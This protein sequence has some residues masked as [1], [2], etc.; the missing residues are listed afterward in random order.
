MTISSTTNTVSYTGNGSTT[1]FAVNYVFFGT[2]TSAE[3]QVVEVVIATG[4]ETVKSNGSD[5]TVSGGNGA[6]GTVTAAV[7]PANTVKWVINRTTTQTQETDY[8]E[9]DP[10]PAESHEEALDRLTAVDQEQ[11]RA[12]DRTAQLPDGYTGSFDPTLPTAI[13][14]STVLAFNAGATA[15]EIGPTTA[16]ISGAAAEAAAAAVS[17]DAS[18]S[19]AAASEAA[20]DE[21]T[22]LYLGAKASDPALDNDGN[23]LQDGALYFDTTLNVMKVYDLGTTTWKRTTPTAGEQANIDIVAAD[24]TDIGTVAGISANVTTVAGISADVTAVAGDATDIGTVAA[25]LAGPDTIGTVAGITANVTTVAGIS[26]DVTTV[27]ADGTDIGTVASNIS[28]VNTVAGNNANITTVAG[29]SSDVTTVAADG[30]DIGTVAG[31]AANV[32]TVA[33]ISSDVTAVAGDATDIGTVAT[34]LTGSNT[35]GTVAGIAANVTTVAGISSDVTTVAADGADIG[36]VAGISANV[37]TVASVSAN[38]TTVAGIAADVTTVAADGTDIGTVAGISSDVTSVAGLSANVTTVAGISG[39]VTTV[40]GIS[41]DVTSVVGIASDVTTVAGISSDVSAVAAQV[42]GY[43]F[44]TTTTMADPGSGNVRF[45]NATL[46]SV[47]AIA[48]DDLDSNGVDQ[49]PYIALWDDSTNTI[50]GTLVFRTVGGDV[51]TFNITGLTDNVGWSQVAVTH[52]ASSGTFSDAEDTFIG[53]TRAG[54]K[55]ADGAGSGDVS[56]PGAA[57]TDNAVVRWDTTSGQLVQSSGVTISDV[58]AITAESLTL[59]TDLAVADGGTGASDAATARSNLGAAAS[60]SNGDITALTGLTTDIAVADGGTG[61]SD[62]STARTNLGLG[63]IATQAANNVSITGGSITGITDLA[64]ADGGTGASDASTARTNLG[65]GSIATQDSSSVSITGGSVTGI[66]DLAVADGGTGASDAGTARTNLGLGSIAT[67]NSNSVSITGGSVTGITDIAV[68]DGGTGASDA[69]TARSNLG[70][71]A[72]GSNSDITALTGLTTDLSVSQGGTGASS[73]TANGVL[74][75]SGTSAIGATAVGTS[76]QVLTSN[77]SGSAPTFQ[78]AGGGSWE[79]LL[80]G[81]VS[82]ASEL[83]IEGSSYINDDYVRYVL[84][85][86]QTASVTASP[87]VTFRQESTGTYLSSLYF[88]AQVGVGGSGSTQSSSTYNTSYVDPGFTFFHPGHNGNIE[89]TFYSLRA[90]DCFSYVSFHGGYPEDYYSKTAVAWGN[91]GVRNNVVIDGMKW[92][93]SLGSFTGR[94][95][96][97]GLKGA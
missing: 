44:S 47:T 38:V 83:A 85:Y 74:Y 62:A 3:I 69:A 94:Y 75:G 79:L 18:A 24:G 8:V 4:A 78:D 23:A 96:W 77:G 31:I 63:T 39:D 46:A 32:T 16:A 40:A 27:A 51:A 20:L 12:L 91:G 9:N 34:D 81:T 52:V 60:G 22:D 33:G 50:K 21:F 54:D 36:T 71:A 15:F 35:I 57:V 55:G 45:N 86:E 58:G 68:A 70:A 59:T 42:V 19:Y 84:H 93:P 65:L 82:A 67:Q 49:S 2:G 61:A 56:G 43:A 17:A 30:T 48:I 6:T 90:S 88:N 5:F 10:F 41:S 95:W 29:I 89:M 11:Q 28:N 76:G 92:T 80:S 26:S 37:T 97:Y 14:G 64:V 73:L 87:R 25:D 1:E 66:T 13:I 7:A 72:S 53:F